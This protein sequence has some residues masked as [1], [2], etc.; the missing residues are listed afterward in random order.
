MLFY[1]KATRRRT[2]KAV[3]LSSGVLLLP[4]I[5]ASLIAVANSIPT[6]A[7][8]VQDAGEGSEGGSGDDNDETTTSSVPNNETS[9]GEAVVYSIWVQENETAGATDVFFAKSEDGGETFSDP[10]NLSSNEEW[11]GSPRI[12]VID[13]HVH[14]VW[15][16]RDIPPGEEF[17]EIDAPSI[18]GIVTVRS[19]ND[20]GETFDDAVLLSEE[21]NAILN[22]GLQIE[23]ATTTA[24]GNNTNDDHNNV[25]I[26]WIAD[27]AEEFPD[28]IGNL[29]FAKSDDSGQ[30]FEVTELVDGVNAFAIEM[31]VAAAAAA[32]DDDDADNIY[33][34][35]DASSE[36]ETPALDQIFFQRS[37]DGGETFDDPIFLEVVEPSEEFVHFESLEVDDDEIQV[38]WIRGDAG[39]DPDSAAT[40]FA[41]ST[42]GGGTWGG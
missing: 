41:V 42:D 26:S 15:V 14:V 2:A 16:D 29:T 33:F 13:N 34:A 12:A 9:G 39:T 1:K 32:S 30:S 40:H 7:A 18:P 20:G 37:T 4:L 3:T 27:T 38:T 35:G 31:E 28:F 19:S 11:S 8:Q 5:L 10:I 22:S 21:P 17:P 36:G 23:A 24:D 25:Y 6:A